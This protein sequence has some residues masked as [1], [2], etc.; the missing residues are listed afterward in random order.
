VLLPF[1]VS[2][3]RIAIVYYVMTRDVRV[4]LSQQTFVVT[5]IGQNIQNYSVTAYDPVTD[6]PVAITIV[7][8]SRNSVSLQILATDIP[9]AMLFDKRG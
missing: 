7:E 1:Q 4:P 9:R 2:A 5:I 6:Q 3:N 8:S